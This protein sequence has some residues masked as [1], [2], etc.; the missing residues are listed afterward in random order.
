M[1]KIL[2]STL[3]MLLFVTSCGKIPTLSNGEE[4]VVTLDD[5]GI[6]VNELYEEM[7]NTYA[8]STLLDLID[9][10]I[11]SEKYPSGEDEESYIKGQLDSMQLYYDYYYK[12]SYPSFEAFVY[13]QYNVSSIDAVKKILG[14][15]YKRN[16]VV[17]EYAKGLVTDKEIQNYYDDDVIAEIRASHILIT[18]DYADGATDEQKAEIDK[19]ALEQAKS[20]ITKLNNGE[21]FEDLA[22]EYSKDNS[23]SNGGDVNWFGHG[24][25]VEEFENAAIKLK[26]GEYTKEP[27]KTKYGYH[28]ILKT[29]EREK[30][31]LEDI[32]EEVIESVAED[33][34]EN[35]KN[36]KILALIDFRKD[37]GIKIE[38][39][40]LAKQY[41]TYIE[42]YK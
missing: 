32:K 9:N 10:K 33:K 38:D 8:L 42:N 19:T 18:T 3:I 21:K 1:K 27:V 24:E 40:E 35:T 31:K 30:A 20:I 4:A 11:L 26:K 23:A 12:E 5:G 34:V 41:K 29:D 13:S 28:I 15:E 6:S 36:I 7:K 37:N 39:P 16:Q 25:M 2:A 22:K 14:L 17:L